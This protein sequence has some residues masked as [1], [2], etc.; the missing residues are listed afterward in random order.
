MA[1]TDARAC[2]FVSYFRNAQ[3]TVEIYSEQPQTFYRDNQLAKTAP[4]VPVTVSR[5]K[6]IR[7]KSLEPNEM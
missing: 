6:M 4:N 3:P 7:M 5:N 1:S 2:S